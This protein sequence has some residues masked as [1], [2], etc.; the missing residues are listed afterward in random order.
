MIKRNGLMYYGTCFEILATNFYK[1]EASSILA[2][3]DYFKAVVSLQKTFPTYRYISDA[4]ITPP[5]A[6]QYS[7][8]DMQSAI[9]ASAFGHGATLV[10]NDKGELKG[11]EHSLGLRGPVG[12]DIF[13]PK[14]YSGNRDCPDK[15]W[16][17]PKGLVA[18]PA[19]SST[20]PATISDSYPANI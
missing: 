18:S 10:C 8:T 2:V 3:V 17:Y 20:T 1:I 7:K 16:C 6:K 15:I 9:A 19:E 12:D 11:V 13:V 14:D 5:M 4:S